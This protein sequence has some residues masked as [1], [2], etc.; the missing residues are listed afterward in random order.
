MV[1][2]CRPIW[3]ISFSGMNISCERPVGEVAQPAS[4]DRAMTPVARTLIMG[5]SSLREATI[6][7]SINRMNQATCT[8]P[9]PYR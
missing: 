2:A 6:I 9:L 5:F 3:V 4:I 8:I 1:N 7:V